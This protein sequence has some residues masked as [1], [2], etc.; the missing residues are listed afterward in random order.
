MTMEGSG[1]AL[2]HGAE[3]TEGAGPDSGGRAGHTPG[4]LAPVPAEPRQLT[5]ARE[6]RALTHPVRLAL[7]EALAIHGTLTATEAGEL[8]G[9]SPTTCSFHL[10]QL[11]RYGFV[12]EAGGGT[13]RRRPWRPAHRSI[14]FSSTEGDSDASVAAI[15]LEHLLISR[16]VSRFEQW[17]RTR[18]GEPR[19]WQDA[20]DTSQ[21]VVYLTPDET[22]D[23]ALAMHAVIEP[24]ADRRTDPST[25]PEGARAVE[26]LTFAFPAQSGKLRS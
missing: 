26:I 1:G 5:D 9:E 15:E 17:E 6:L 20:A 14:R 18:F 13:G 4:G 23:V 2:G 8:I 22:R 7:L 3:T 25:R 24:F 10:R 16:W 12:E 11:A 21:S 19:E